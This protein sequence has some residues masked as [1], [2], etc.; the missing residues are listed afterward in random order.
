MQPFISL[1]S[2]L[3]NN[4]N[5]KDR[6]KS[7]ALSVLGLLLMQTLTAQTRSLYAY[8]DLSNI[9]YAKQKDSLTKNWVCPVLSGDKATQKKYREIW[10][11]RTEFITAAMAGNNF[12]HDEEIYRY[13][14]NIISQIAK[15]NTKLITAKPLLLIDRSAAV[16]A[17]AIGGNIIAVNLGLIT[18]AQTKEDIALVIAHELSHNILNHAD[19]AMKE[20]A[21]WLASD[22]YKASL[23]SVLSS[24]YERYSRLKKVF[25]NYSFSR[26]RHQRYHESDADSLAVV[27]LK[28]SNLAF[29]PS[30]FLSL[31]SADDNY[32]QP[33][34]NALPT[35][36]TAYALPCEE[37]WQQ[38]R[39]RGLSTHAYSF[40]D[41]TGVADSL[42]THPDCQARY[43]ALL[44]QATQGAKLTVIPADLQEKANKMLIWNMFDGQSLTPC[45]YRVLQQK[46]KGNKDEWYDMMLYAIFSGLYYADKQLSRFNAIGITQKEHVSKSYYELQTMLEQMPRETLETYCRELSNKNFW[47]NMTP[48]AKALKA[49]FNTVNFNIAAG[50]TKDREEAARLFTNTNVNSMYC[51]FADHFKKK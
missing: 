43:E 3:V 14:D 36:F 42:K 45:L 22:E 17:Y 41:T 10:D 31:D 39:T 5:L 26:S 9:Y 33:L 44:P 11:S 19:N 24:R 25:E 48:D 49:L 27:L 23:Q 51:E 18:Y 13:I 40:K 12:V 7:I 16:N 50:E 4:Q 20:K 15:S 1:R 46:D 34:K 37:A 38:K 8:Q 32:Q 2:P 35:Y 30:F 28:N 47:Q 29:E 6:F 21:G